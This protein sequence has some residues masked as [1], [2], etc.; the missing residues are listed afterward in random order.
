M[1]EGMAAG[2]YDVRILMRKREKKDRERKRDRKGSNM[3]L[4]FPLWKKK[5]N[6]EIFQQCLVVLKRAHL[7]IPNLKGIKYKKVKFEIKKNQKMFISLAPPV[8]E[9]TLSFSLPH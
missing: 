7:R 8:S 1:K 4:C 9:R 5:E 6:S 2:L 3:V